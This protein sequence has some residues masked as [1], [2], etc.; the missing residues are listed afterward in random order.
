MWIVSKGRT[1]QHNFFNLLSNLQKL[2]LSNGSKKRAKCD[3][4]GIK[5]AI[6]KKLQKFPNYRL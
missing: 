3:P 1:E 4:N 5:I 6:F 2:V